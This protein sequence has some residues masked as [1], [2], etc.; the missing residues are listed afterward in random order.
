MNPIHIPAPRRYRPL[1]AAALLCA[2]FGSQAADGV[3]T[4]A[5]SGIGPWIAA[6]G[7]AALRELGDEL[8]RSLRQQMQ[9]LLPQPAKTPDAPG[10]APVTGVADA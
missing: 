10:Q 7:N 4:R 5:A 2:S 8:R 9:P 1:I 6:Q 3:A